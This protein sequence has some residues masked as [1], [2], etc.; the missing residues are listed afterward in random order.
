M[1][2]DPCTSVEHNKN[3]NP[4]KG[5]NPMN[6]V[7]YKAFEVLHFICAQF[8]VSVTLYIPVI[9]ECLLKVGFTSGLLDSIFSLLLRREEVD[10]VTFIA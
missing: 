4:E 1:E 3:A 7:S 5:L 9:T 8:G 2:A 10:P 6:I